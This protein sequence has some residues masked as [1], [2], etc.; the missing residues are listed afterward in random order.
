[1]ERVD[2][3]RPLITGTSRPQRVHTRMYAHS[4]TFSARGYTLV[5][6][7]WKVEKDINCVIQI[8]L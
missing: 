1:M 3:L 8:L 4:G 5:G 2:D 6:T 7:R